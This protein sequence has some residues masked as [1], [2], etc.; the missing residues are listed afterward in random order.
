MDGEAGELEPLGGGPPWRTITL[1]AMAVLGVVTL[2]A[3]IFTVG[4]ANRERDRALVAQ[5][6][7]YD[8][9]I[10]ARTLAGTIARSEASLGRYVISTDRSLGQLYF[11]EWRSAAAQINYLDRLTTSDADQQGR[12]DAL[13][14]AYNDRG[15]ELSMIAL[16]TRYG[17]N[18]QA[19]ARYHQARNARSLRVIDRSLSRI[20]RGE[21]QILDRRTTAAMLLVERSTAAAVGLAVFGGMLVLGAVL[22]GWYTVSTLGESAIARAEADAAQARAD[23]LATAVRVATDELR[24]QEAKLRQVQKMDAVGQL[25]GGIAHDFNNMLAVVLG[26]LELARRNLGKESAARHLDSATEGAVRAAALTRRLLAFSREEALK[27]E[28]V[29]PGALVAGMSDLLDRTLGDAV[30]IRVRDEAAGWRTHADRVQLE[31]ALLNLA[32]NARDAMNG[33]GDLTIVTGTATLGAGA[34]GQCAGGEY[35]TFAVTDSGCGMAPEVA[36][37]VFEPFFTTKPVGKGT[38][39]GLSQIFGFVRQQDGEVG[40]DSAPGRGTTVTL[41]LPR[42]LGER[43][44]ELPVEPPPEAVAPSATLKVLVVEDDPRVLAATMGALDELG[45]VG[46]ACDDPLRA[47]G[48]VE[49]DGDIELV[50]SDVLMPRQTGPE[51]V[52]GLTARFPGLAILYVTGYAGDAGGANEFG[53]HHVLRKPFTLSAIERAITAAMADRAAFPEQIAAE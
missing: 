45:H 27:P 34:V 4:A 2:A 26:G 5:G 15:A 50:I 24:I 41:Y 42:H 44:A 30:T 8:V 13:R 14:R 31:N 16:S 43:A 28:P 32:V 47:P 7:S 19:L 38:G 20:I 10:V 25:T 18:G 1:I 11:D 29:D 21:R 40:I 12:I 46:I 35:V 37:R 33:R 39:L 53:G 49:R 36:E 17:K 22:L 48:I 6:R 52:A 23:E 3:L 51:M 9:M